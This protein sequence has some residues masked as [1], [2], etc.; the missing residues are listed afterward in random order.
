VAQLTA[1]DA[2]YADL[3]SALDSSDDAES[4]SP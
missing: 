2:D 1:L 3:Y 4:V